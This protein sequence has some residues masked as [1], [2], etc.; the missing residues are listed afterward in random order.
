MT[1]TFGYGVYYIS[2]EEI[3]KRKQA[4]VPEPDAKFI[5][6]NDIITSWFL[7]ATQVDIVRRAVA[8]APVRIIHTF[9]FE[10][11]QARDRRDERHTQKA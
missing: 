2:S 7:D 10:A 3:D 9:S 11:P 6:T 5:S 8:I 4:H 1:P